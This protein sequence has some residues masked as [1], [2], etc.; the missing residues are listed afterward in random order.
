LLFESELRAG[1]DDLI[2]NHKFRR[3]QYLLNQ[4]DRVGAVEATRKLVSSVEPSHGFT[5]LATMG[6][7][8]RSLESSVLGFTGPCPIFDE[9]VKRSARRK[10]GR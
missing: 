4:I 1:I 5:D 2:N 8:D 3:P 7:L 6:L 10:L 9:G